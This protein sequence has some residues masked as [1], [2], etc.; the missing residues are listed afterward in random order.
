MRTFLIL[1]LLLVALFACACSLLE[2]QDRAA[3]RANADD[4][5][6]C[7][8][9]DQEQYHR[10]IGA[11]DREAAGDKWLE[12]AAIFAGGMLG[13]VGGPPAARGVRAVARKIT[14]RKVVA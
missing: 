14:Q 10:I 3:L 7:G 5:Y 1:W 13:G 9:I 8:Y 12:L 11:L 6:A 2:P 4:A